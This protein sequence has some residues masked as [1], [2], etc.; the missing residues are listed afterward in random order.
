MPSLKQE[1]KFEEWRKPLQLEES[2]AAV[3]ANT[4]IRVDEF[5]AKVPLD[6]TD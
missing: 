5:Y 1:L 2:G 3:K 4:S 6:L